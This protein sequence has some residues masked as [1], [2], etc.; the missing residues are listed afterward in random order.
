MKKILISVFI[1]LIIL[2]V[3]CWSVSIIY[4]EIITAVHGK[5]FLKFDEVK[6]ASR[7]KILTYKENYA[8]IYCVNFDRSAGTIHSFI[9]RDG[10]WEY[11]AW[12]EGGWSKSGS[13]DGFVW[14]YI[15]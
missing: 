7:F 10:E 2:L 6:K 1:I 11:N 13:A 9:K 3:V 12:E 15:R 14:P 4:C 5:E 8:R